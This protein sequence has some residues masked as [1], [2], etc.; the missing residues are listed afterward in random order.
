MKFALSGIL[1][2]VSLT[3]FAQEN[4]YD[5]SCAQR[6]IEGSVALV[7][8]AKDFN[9]ERID[10]IQYSFEVATIVAE[11]NAMRIYCINE[12]IPAQECIDSTKPTY[13][14]IRNK[15]YVKEVLKG[16]LPRVEVSE[17]DLI[18]LTKGAVKGF[19]KRIKRGES[20]NLCRLSI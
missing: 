13:K 11:I 3:T 4:N 19:L 2:L 10:E 5:Y 17:L 14:N 20:E 1:L 15:M 12:G 7:Q 18:P 9:Q 6:Y 16:D 8:T